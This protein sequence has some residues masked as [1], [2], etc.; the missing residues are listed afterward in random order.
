[1]SAT[2]SAAGGP[3]YQTL[4]VHRDSEGNAAVAE[5]QLSRP[6]LL[7]RFDDALHHELIAVIEEVTRDDGV[8]AVVLSSTG[9]Y[10]SAGGD[11]EI[12]LAAAK[13]IQVRMAMLDNGRRLFR[14]LADFP[15]PLVVA[16]AGDTFG[17][18]ATVVLLG[19]AVV[20]APDV[21]I[22]DTHVRMGLVAGDG[23]AVAWPVNMPLARAKRHLLTGDP[24]TGAEAHQFGLVSDLV[25]DRSEVR[26]AALALAARLADLPPLA[27]QLTKRALNKYLS[28]HTDD[29]LDLGFYL[30]A[31]TMGS[32]DMLEAIAA[33][34]EK[35]PGRWTGR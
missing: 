29:V 14:A 35:R 7:N 3:T 31:I 33:F 30:E 2:G 6:E 32:A 13:D 26:P 8:L 23:G 20:T 5:I 1:M 21:K 18:G 22:A 19:D 28:S 15:K 4:T 25:A 27:V 16:L 11:T 17:L 9:K 12:M 24:L 10:F 34:Q